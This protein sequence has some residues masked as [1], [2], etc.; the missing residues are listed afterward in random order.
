MTHA[1]LRNNL[2][3]AFLLLALV[4]LILYFALPGSHIVGLVVIGIA[5]IVKIVEF[6]IRFMF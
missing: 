2:N 3:A 5:M 1:E 4:G 6:F